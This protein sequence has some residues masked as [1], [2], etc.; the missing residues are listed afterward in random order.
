MTDTEL[1]ATKLLGWVAEGRGYYHREY[2]RSFMVYLDGD[3]RARIDP[4]GDWPDFTTLDGCREFELALCDRGLLVQYFELLDAVSM[5]GDEIRAK[6]LWK[7]E[8]P[9]PSHIYRLYVCFNASPDQRVA[10]CVRVI[11]EA[12][13]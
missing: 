11:Q 5:A 7:H 3:G 2:H 13:L 1:I 8:S 12:G 9:I 6:G 10:A 4:T